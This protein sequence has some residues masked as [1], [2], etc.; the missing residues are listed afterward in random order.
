EGRA[1]QGE[2]SLHHRP[3]ADD[4]RSAR[5][6]DP[7]DGECLGGDLWA[8]PGGV[9]HG[10][11]EEGKALGHHA[12]PFPK[13]AKRPGEPKPPALVNKGRGAPPPAT[14][15]PRARPWAGAPSIS[16]WWAPSALIT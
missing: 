1:K 2:G 15:R 11:T 4:Q 7:G 13:A 3:V 6:H 10:D 8:D 14:R 12:D 9:S 5:P 16:R